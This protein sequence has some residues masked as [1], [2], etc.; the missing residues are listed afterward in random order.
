M[1]KL[2]IY[3]AAVNLLAG[4]VFWYDKSQAVKNK[5][6]GRVPERRLR[7]L[8]AAGGVFA[9]VLLVFVIRH[10]NKKPA[11]YWQTFVL[12]FFW[13]VLLYVRAV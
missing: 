8:E 3:L 13:T 4:A 2:F 6:K 7:F 9:I 1:E 10:K 11:Y 12:L 5:G